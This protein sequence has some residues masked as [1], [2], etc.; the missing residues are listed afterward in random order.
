MARKTSI[1]ILALNSN[2]ARYCWRM[3]G[4]SPAS[5]LCLSKDW[6]GVVLHQQPPAEHSHWNSEPDPEVWGHCRDDWPG[7]CCQQ[8]G[9]I[10]LIVESH[11]LT[12]HLWLPLCDANSLGLWE[13]LI[14][15]QSIQSCGKK[16]AF[17]LLDDRKG[18]AADLVLLASP[19]WMPGHS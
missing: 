1:N 5:L 9:F 10:S 12:Q 19:F 4:C 8:S 11:D 18:C 3:T 2:K 7:R 14:C 16:E 6:A 13:N 15:G 17:V